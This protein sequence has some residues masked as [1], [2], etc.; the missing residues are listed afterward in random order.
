MAAE[1]APRV[2]RVERELG[3]VDGVVRVGDRRAD[4]VARV[5]V[6]EV[7]LH[8]LLLEIGVDLILEKE[9]DVPEPDIARSIFC[10]R[11][12]R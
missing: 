4:R 3:R 9:A 5:D 12:L 10:T 8:P 1:R 2:G 7:D 6:L 11:P